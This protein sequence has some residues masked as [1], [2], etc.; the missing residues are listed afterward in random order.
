M[1]NVFRWTL[2]F[3]MGAAVVYIGATAAGSWLDPSYSQVTQHVSD[4]TATGAPTAGALAPLYVTYNLL[5]VG[6]AIALYLASDRGWLFKL[7]SGL[8]A[9]NALAGVMMVTWFRE[10]LGGLPK[11]ASGTGHLVFAGISVIA[12]L[13]IAFVF[14]V[15]FRR[16]AFW[17][18]LANFSFAVG[19]GI[20]ILGPLGVL[21]TAAKSNLAGLAERGPIGLFMLWLLGIAIFVMVKSRR[22]TLP[23]RADRKQVA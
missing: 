5:E 20:L 8:L 3:G 23:A 2:Y 1:T 22:R 18:P 21:A 17:R 16:A 11:T 19:A 9:L 12:T 10:D 7:G 6:L 14:A 4:L 13:G 15:A